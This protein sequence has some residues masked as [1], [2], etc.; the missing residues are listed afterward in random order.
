MKTLDAVLNRIDQ[1]IDHSVER[2]FALLRIASVSTDPAF[3]DQ[4][5]AAAEHVATDL[6]SIGFEATVRPTAGH[7]VVV[8]KSNGA[9]GP[10]VLF[11]GHYDVQ[12]VDPLSLWKTPPFEPRIET[13]PDG[14]KIIVARGACDDKGQAM[15]FIEAC[16]AFKAVTGKLPLPITMMIEGEE[17]CGSKNLFGFVRDNAAEFKLDLA[18][19]CDT[20]MWD[21]KTP[22]VTTSLRGLVYEDVKITCADRDLHSGVFGGAAQNPLR[23]LSQIL[24]EMWDDKGRVTIPGFYDGVKDLPAD[25]KAD[26][27]GLGL[28]AEKFLGPIGLKKPAGEQ[29][30]MVIEMVT[31]RPT[32]EINGIIGGYTG[33]GAKTVIPGEASAKVS[34]RLVGEQD[35]EKIRDAFR[36]FVRARLPA[37]CKVEFGN[38]GLAP[39]IQLS[40][41]N[42]ALTKARAVLADEWGHKAVAVGAGGSIPIVADFKNVL[43]MDSLLVG[44]AL[45][46]D[47]VHSPNE[48]FD[49]KCY[50]KGIRSWAR[51]LDALS[52]G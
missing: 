17:E 2:L 33:E 5:R 46:D 50:H 13:L 11:Y 44:F 28:T 43:G 10:R 1:E 16:R 26:L 37:D 48:K 3:K 36:A 18:L 30:R 4:C 40:F 42:S 32:A 23:L 6:K 51:I 22:A 35:P 15:T 19:V 47:R 8:G 21:Q 24:G 25:I 41:D 7:P 9:A 39:P 31:T 20:A 27:K 12:P 49:L 34:F 29:D 14:R 38:F 52:S 45:D